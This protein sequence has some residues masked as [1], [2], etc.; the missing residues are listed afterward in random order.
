MI[1]SI[2]VSFFFLLIFLTI[3]TLS[4]HFWVNFLDHNKKMTEKYFSLKNL[5]S[6]N[7]VR[8]IPSLLYLISR[9]CTPPEVKFH[10]F[11]RQNT[12]Q[13][14]FYRTIFLLYLSVQWGH[15]IKQIKEKSVICTLSH[16]PL[17]RTWTP[18]WVPKFSS[19]VY[20]YL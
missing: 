20:C 10:V 13:E 17:M 11:V 19:H 12:G 5:T 15:F 2:Q 14:N 9:F 3:N 1:Q 6:W 4:W 16:Q 8:I 7:D 18:A